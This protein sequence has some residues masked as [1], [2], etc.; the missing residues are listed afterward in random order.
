MKLIVNTEYQQKGSLP[1]NSLELLKSLKGRRITRL[2]K[3][4][5]WEPI[6]FSRIFGVE[7]NKLFE[8]GCG[9]LFIEFDRKKT[10]SLHGYLKISSV[11]IQ[12]ETKEFSSIQRQSLYWINPEDSEFSCSNWMNLIGQKVEMLEIANYED[13]Y[14]VYGRQGMNERGIVFTSKERKFVFCHALTSKGPIDS[15]IMDFNCIES[16]IL[17]KVRLICV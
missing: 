4:L 1:S 10:I 9:T 7:K 15:V 2:G 11:T 17:E 12:E 8:L 13:D 3:S 14:K 16:D 6:E 5:S